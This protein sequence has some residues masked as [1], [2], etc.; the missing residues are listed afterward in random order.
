MAGIGAGHRERKHLECIKDIPNSSAVKG[1][2]SPSSQ[3][4]PIPPLSSPS[5]PS[6][7]SLKMRRMRMRMRMRIKMILQIIT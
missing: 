1:S 7:S 6:F 2:L 4:S 3:G 5:S